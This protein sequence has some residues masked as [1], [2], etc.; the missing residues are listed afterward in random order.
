MVTARLRSEGVGCGTAPVSG[1]ASTSDFARLPSDIGSLGLRRR[2]RLSNPLTSAPSRPVPP[3]R[4]RARLPAATT[5]QFSLEEVRG[6]GDASRANSR[7]TGPATPTSPEPDATVTLPLRRK[8][9]S[10]DTA[11]SSAAAQQTNDDKGES[12][13][14]LHRADQ[15][16]GCLR[17]LWAY[18][19][20]AV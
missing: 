5:S 3:R 13:V 1:V 19:L 17:R 11:P 10:A 9:N 12:S 8:S 4:R 16:P 7:T 6:G 20:L 18:T 15:S 2:R 14:L